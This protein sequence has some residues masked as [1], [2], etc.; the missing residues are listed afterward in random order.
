MGKLTAKQQRFCDEYLIDLNAT[1]AAIRA[2]Y[3]EK[4]AYSMGQ[5]LLKNVEIQSEISKRQT[6]RSERTEITQD[7]VLRELAKIAFSDYNNYVSIIER[8]A[9]VISEDNQKIMLYDEKGKPVMVKD[10]DFVL[11]DALPVDTKQ[12]I[13]SIKKGRAGI[14]VELY[15][16]EKAL[17]LL[18]KHLGMFTGKQEEE[19]E[20][21]D[22]GFLEALKGTAREDWSDEE[23]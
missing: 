20:T 23:D 4:T 18:G 16:K 13:K 14:E 7:M 10:I 21:S 9:Y 15:D 2:G 11:T 19:E 1:Q 3:S 6:A 12:A 22:D 17:E 5:R 8:Q